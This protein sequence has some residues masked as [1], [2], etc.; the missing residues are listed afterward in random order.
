MHVTMKKIAEIAGV[1]ESTVSRALRNS[2]EVGLETRE[3]IREIAR[4]LNFHP[5]ALARGLA[6]RKS[7]TVGLIITSISNLYFAK[8]VR[9]VEEHADA[10]GYKVLLSTTGGR[11]SKELEAIAVMR[12][13][14]VDGLIYMSGR[15]PSECLTALK[16]AGMP[17]VVISR[18]VDDPALPYVGIDNVAEAYRATRYLLDLGHRDIGFIGGSSDDPEAGMDR[19]TGFMKALADA[20]ITPRPEWIAE[21]RFEF[22]YAYAAASTI[23]KRRPRPSAVFAASDEMAAGVIRAAREK[24][25][26][27]PDDLSV[28]GFD[29]TILAQ[30]VEPPLTTISQPI[31]DLGHEAM[32]VLGM[33]IDGVALERHRFVFE[34]QLLERSSCA[35]PASRD[36]KQ[37]T[38][39]SG[40]RPL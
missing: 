15:A 18:K 35:P 27:V 23:L 29:N 30:M 9:G 26:K 17:V 5:N 7:E 39:T 11:K 6:R 3:R 34:C 14:R 24:G 10:L 36:R 25:L 13:K 32:H 20:G 1:S 21:G 28:L 22:E 8:A 4:D 31:Y 38:L 19:Q 37:K 40:G 16:Q 2:R 33:M 12:E